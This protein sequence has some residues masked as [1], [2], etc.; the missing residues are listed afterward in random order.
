MNEFYN[1]SDSKTLYLNESYFNISYYMETLKLLNCHKNNFYNYSAIYVNNFS[2]GYKNKLD[3]IIKNFSIKVKEN[4]ID[5]F[6]IDEF[7]Q[8][9]GFE[10]IKNIQIYDLYYCFEEIENMI[11]YAN[12]IKNEEYENILFNLLISSFNSSYDYFTKIFY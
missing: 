12:F 9:F 3:N 10:E 6:F 1:I 4:Y 2:E 7:L 11:N 5:E 8:T